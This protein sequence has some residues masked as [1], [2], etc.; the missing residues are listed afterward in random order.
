MKRLKLFAILT[1]ALLLFGSCGQAAEIF[2][3]RMPAE[4]AQSAALS[5]AAPAPRRRCDH[6]ADNTQTTGLR[7][8]HALR[9]RR[10]VIGEA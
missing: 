9:L 7:P 10:K 1:A 4:T 3:I 2:R 8:T 5:S 6:A